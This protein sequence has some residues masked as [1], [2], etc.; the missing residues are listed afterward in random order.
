MAATNRYVI[1]FVEVNRAPVPRPIC[2]VPADD[3]ELYPRGY[4][5][6]RD[7]WNGL[8]RYFDVVFNDR[9]DWCEPPWL[10]EVSRTDDDGEKTPLPVEVVSSREV[11]LVPYSRCDGTN[12]FDLTL[13]A[14]CSAYA[15]G[16]RLTKSDGVGCLVFNAGTRRSAV[17]AMKPPTRLD[18]QEEIPF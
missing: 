13:L 2:L 3:L 7:L 10:P 14:P 11:A 9:F 1:H 4:L 8:N 12:T 5:E 17:A 15:T 18:D 6:N 16:M